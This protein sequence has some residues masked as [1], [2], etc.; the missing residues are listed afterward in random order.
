MWQVCHVLIV[1]AI[2]KGKC[3]YNN[4]TYGMPSHSVA[5]FVE[6]LKVCTLLLS[7]RAL[8]ICAIADSSIACTICQGRM[9]DCTRRER[10]LW[11]GRHVC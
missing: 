4:K 9:V 7:P 10:I 3:R 11:L 6:V 2:C 5:D 8:Q 1:V